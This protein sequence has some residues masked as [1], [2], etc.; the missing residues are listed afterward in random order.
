MLSSLEQ[1]D[2]RPSQRDI[3]YG[4]REVIEAFQL[5]H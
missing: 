5:T 3:R 4:T 2:K 1:K